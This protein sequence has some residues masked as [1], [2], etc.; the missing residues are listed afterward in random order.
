MLGAIISYVL[1]TTD[2]FTL[3]YLSNFEQIGIYSAAFKITSI[4]AIVR[5]AFTT[6]WIPKSYQIYDK[7]KD[8][9]LFNDIAKFV[10]SIVGVIFFLIT[11]FKDAI[12]LVLGKEYRQAVILL[13][14]VLLIP[15]SNILSDI[16]GIGITGSRKTYWNAIIVSVAAF[17]NLIGN[18]ILVPRM[19]ALG[20]AIS[21]GA[22]YVWFMWLRILISKYLGIKIF[23]RRIKLNTLLILLA[24]LISLVINGIIYQISVISV[25]FLIFTFINRRELSHFL[26]MCVNINKGR[27]T[28][29]KGH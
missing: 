9:N 8:T 17:L 20:A 4:I 21:S 15:I 16:F 18:V 12:V 24:A 29:G 1:Q 6:Y 28:R 11:I 22:S 2:R 27:Q 23:L 3:R 10:F 19:G 26:T 14:W 25:L 7:D 13:P 5:G